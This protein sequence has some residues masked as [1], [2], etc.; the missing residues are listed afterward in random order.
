MRLLEHAISAVGDGMSRDFATGFYHTKAWKKT[1][2]AYYRYRRGL[3][4]HCLRLGKYV[5]GEIV[6]HKVHLTP[7]NISDP[8]VS[9]SFDN[10]ELLCR[11]CHALAHPEAYPEAGGGCRVEFDANGDVVER[12]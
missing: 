9:L 11:E 12:R 1:R 3:C 8:S 2:A 6:H 7:E 4:E 10:L 5:P